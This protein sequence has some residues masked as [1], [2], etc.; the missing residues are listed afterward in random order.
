MFYLLLFPLN[1]HFN[2]AIGDLK[3]ACLICQENVKLH[4]AL[5]YNYHNFVCDVIDGIK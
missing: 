4:L 1:D 3:L 2:Y 5:L